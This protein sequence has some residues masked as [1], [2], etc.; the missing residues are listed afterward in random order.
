MTPLK[1]VEVVPE[2]IK[3]KNSIK[4]SDL[5]IFLTGQKPIQKFNNRIYMNS[6]IDAVINRH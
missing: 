1:T 6:K 3:R 4:A 5:E 2:V